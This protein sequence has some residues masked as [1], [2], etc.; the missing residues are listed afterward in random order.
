MESPRPTSSRDQA[1][2]GSADSSDDALTGR[3]EAQHRRR[4]RHVEA[5]GPAVV[6]DRHPLVDRG[7]VGQPVCLV[8]DDERDPP[9]QIGLGVG[10]P[11]VRRRADGPQAGRSAPTR[12]RRRARARRNSAPADAR[13][14]LGLNGSTEPA[15]STTPST[16]A[17]SAERRIVPRLPGSAIRSATTTRSAAA[18]SSAGGGMRT[19]ARTGCGDSVEATPLDHPGAELERA[20]DPVTGSVPTATNSASISHPASTAST[21]SWRP[22]TTNAPSSERELRRPSRRRSRWTLALLNASGSFRALP[23]PPPRATRTRRCR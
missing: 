16:P 22:S 11:S 15:V 2:H 17:A 21:T 3:L 19:T 7:I 12:G 18:R 6:A 23:W 9:G 20:A 10:G 1:V 13:T 14:T 4:H 5:L 8:A